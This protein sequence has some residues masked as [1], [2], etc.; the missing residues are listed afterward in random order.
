M[1]APHRCCYIVLDKEQRA[2]FEEF[3]VAN[4]TYWFYKSLEQIEQDV[5]YIK[6]IQ[7]N[8]EQ[9]LKK[10]TTGDFYWF[11][12]KNAQRFKHLVDNRLNWV[13]CNKKDLDVL[14]QEFKKQTGLNLFE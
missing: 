9:A 7:S 8:Y 14:N 10:K 5:P 1:K 13:Y 2:Y 12:G 11:A 3:F 6:F 4:G